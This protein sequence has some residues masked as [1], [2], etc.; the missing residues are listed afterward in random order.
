LLKESV[1]IIKETNQTGYVFFITTC[2][3]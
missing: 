2:L 1:I 3:I